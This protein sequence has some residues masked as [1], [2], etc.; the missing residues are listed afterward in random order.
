M[1]GQSADT[2]ASSQGLHLFGARQLFAG[3]CRLHVALMNDMA[4]DYIRAVTWSDR[5]CWCPKKDA[6]ICTIGSNYS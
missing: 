4:L 1:R 2:E 5:A 3:T 6:L